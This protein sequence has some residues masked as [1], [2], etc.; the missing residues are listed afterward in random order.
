VRN[1]RK[2][3]ALSARINERLK[4]VKLTARAASLKAGLPADAIRTIFRGSVPSADIVRALAPVLQTSVDVLAGGTAPPAGFGE[5]AAPYG[6]AGEVVDLVGLPPD[7]RIFIRDLVDEL[8]APTDSE[9]AR[10]F[11]IFAVLLEEWRDSKQPFNARSFLAKA[12]KLAELYHLP[13]A[14]QRGRRR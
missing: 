9:M 8:R 5:S 10:L 4:T 3:A 11:A 13:A 14:A 1:P 12:G 2:T 6:A 7:Y